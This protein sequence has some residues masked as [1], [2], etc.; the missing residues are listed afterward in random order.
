MPGPLS[1]GPATLITG[2]FGLVGASLTRHLLETE[3]GRRVVVLDRA[4]PDAA[5]VAYLAGHGDRLQA[6]LGDIADPSVL[7]RVDGEGVDRVVHAAMVAH[8]PEWE[9]ERP[10]S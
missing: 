7:E 9:R 4:E 3:P 10:R 5:A 1:R 8:V 6:V 2:G